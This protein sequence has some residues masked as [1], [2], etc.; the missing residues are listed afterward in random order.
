MI[1]GLPRLHRRDVVVVEN[2][3]PIHVHPIETIPLLDRVSSFPRRENK[4]RGEKS[5]HSSTSAAYR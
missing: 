2:S 4:Q 1:K 3:V 5:R